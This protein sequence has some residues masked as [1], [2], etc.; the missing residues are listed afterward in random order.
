PL[1]VRIPGSDWMEWDPSA[2]G[3]D[4]DQCVKLCLALSELGVDFLDVSSGGLMAAQNV[5]SRPGYQ[6]AFSRAV[7]K[8]LREN[9]LEKNTKVGAVGMIISGVQAEELLQSGAAYAVLV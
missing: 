5:V 2:N 3:W 6:T 9:G 1:L 7:R 8:A 4:V